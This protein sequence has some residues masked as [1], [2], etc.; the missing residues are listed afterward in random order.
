MVIRVVTAN[1][2]TKV[3]YLSVGTLEKVGAAGRV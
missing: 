3:Y 1:L 2:S